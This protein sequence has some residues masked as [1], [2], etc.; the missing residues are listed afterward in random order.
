MLTTILIIAFTVEV[1]FAAYGL[2]TKKNPE[3]ARNRIR[4][5][6]FAVFSIF[7]F[8]SVIQWN[9]RWYG[10]AILLFIWAD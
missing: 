4:I 8:F 6:S 2:I 7:I 1:I 9:F 10:L 3:K 5:T